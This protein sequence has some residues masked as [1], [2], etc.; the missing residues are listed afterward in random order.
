[1]KQAIQ[2]YIPQPCHENWDNMLPTEKG[3]F[4]QACTKQVVDF[5]N[6]TDQ[7]LLHYFSHASGNVCGRLAADQLGRPLQPSPEPLKKR[8]WFAL[9]PVLLLA[10]VNAQKKTTHPTVKTA[11]AGNL[12][13]IQG[14]LVAPGVSIYGKVTGF[15]SLPLAYA[16]VWVKELDKGVICDAG[17]HYT[18]WLNG[19]VKQLTLVASA[20]GYDTSTVQV[21][22][23]IA[24]PYH[25]C[26]PVVPNKLEDITVKTTETTSSVNFV[27]GITVCKPV[28]KADT[29][30]V[31]RLLRKPAFN[32][33]LHTVTHDQE[34]MTVFPNPVRRVQRLT[35]VS[36]SADNFTL[37]VISNSGALLF[38]QHY[39]QAKKQALTI[40]VPQQWTAGLYY[41][42][43]ADEKNKKQ[44]TRKFLVQ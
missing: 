35:V 11:R 16:S 5:S 43:L 20:V 42:R 29:S 44:Y 2:L 27:G 21:T 28:T 34:D 39:S 12:M 26:L 36:R 3:R 4:C 13:Q 32:L 38:S 18:L 6:M 7:Q 19:Q 17:G 37:Q 40:P 25:I 23:P 31:T 10:R 15:D 9:L 30:F 41:L 22:L 14:E 33:T 8:W 1:M 24:G